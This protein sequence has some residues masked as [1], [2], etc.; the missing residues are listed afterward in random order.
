M[1]LFVILSLMFHVVPN[2]FF[3]PR[4]SYGVDVKAGCPK[5]A[6]PEGLTDLRMT[7]KEFACGKAFDDAS[8]FCGRKHGNRL[9]KKVDMIFISTYFDEGNFIVLCDCPTDVFQRFFDGFRKNFLSALHGANKMV[10]EEGDIVRLPLVIAHALNATLGVKAEGNGASPGE[11]DPD[12]IE[13]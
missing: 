11:S 9:K 8:E 2:G 1:K 13:M 12:G 4:S 10:E 7:I 6:V 3:I 5:P